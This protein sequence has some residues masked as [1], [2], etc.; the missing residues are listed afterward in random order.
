M[1]TLEAFYFLFT[2]HRKT[3]PHLI[4]FS[5]TIPLFSELIPIIELKTKLEIESPI[6]SNHSVSFHSQASEANTFADIEAAYKCLVEVYGTREEDIILYG[7]SVGSGPT[8]DLAA[9]LHRI[10]AVVLH[11]PILSGL[12]V[13]YS[14]KKT[15]WFDIYKVCLTDD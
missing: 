15:Y 4:V 9:Q 8:V 6:E 13:M 1:E 12:R 11:S 14:V 2:R 5:S 3:E 10:R 7:Q